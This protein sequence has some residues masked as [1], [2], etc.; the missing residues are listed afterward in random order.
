MQLRGVANL[1]EARMDT[2]MLH[3]IQERLDALP[4]DATFD[5]RTLMGADWASIQH[6]Q[7]FGRMFKAALTA[8]KLTGFKH[9]E[10]N[11]SPRRDVYR[12]L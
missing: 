11:N 3:L 6:K 4:R 7:S 2:D 10:L 12:K 5:V 9:H 8:G 1:K